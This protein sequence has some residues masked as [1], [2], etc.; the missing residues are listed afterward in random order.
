MGIEDDI[1]N[2]VVNVGNWVLDI[3]GFIFDFILPDIADVLTATD[4]LFNEILSIQDLINDTVGFILQAIS[5]L[6]I[7]INQIIGIVQSIATAVLTIP[8]F[9][10]DTLVAIVLEIRSLF[11]SA[12]RNLVPAMAKL[13]MLISS[14][15]TTAVAHINTYITAA[16]TILKQAIEAL[17]GALTGIADSVI[18]VID[19]VA[20]QIVGTLTTII[21]VLYEKFKQLIYLGYEVSLTAYKEI[22]STKAIGYAFY[23][24]TAAVGSLA[25]ESVGS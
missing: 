3:T 18:S 9:F 2:Y 16:M 24:A 13:T 15:A 17:F 25:V 7:P 5:D 12:T 1:Y 20:N 14:T 21:D 4:F 10:V 19:Q 6:G 8:Q 22:G 11:E 23:F